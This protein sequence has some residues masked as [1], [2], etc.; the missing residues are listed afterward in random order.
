MH[1]E[2]RE[3][4]LVALAP[5]HLRRARIARDD[6]RRAPVVV[7][8]QPGEGQWVRAIDILPGD[9]DGGDMQSPRDLLRLRPRWIVWLLVDV[10]DLRRQFAQR[11]PQPTVDIQ[12][13]VSVEHHR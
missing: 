5:H 1:R 2:D 4:P 13:I 6:V 12:V 7:V 9:E 10:D 11:L 8:F 3:W